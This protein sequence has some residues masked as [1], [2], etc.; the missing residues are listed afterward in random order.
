MEAVTSALTVV[1]QYKPMGDSTGGIVGDVGGN[2]VSAT[3]GSVM[4][5]RMSSSRDSEHR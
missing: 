3:P 1:M 2:S 5:T 4:E